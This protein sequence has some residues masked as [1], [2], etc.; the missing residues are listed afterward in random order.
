M[1]ICELT[2]IPRKDSSEG[3]DAFTKKFSY[4]IPHSKTNSVLFSQILHM[5][6]VSKLV[7]VIR[8]G[9]NILV[10]GTLF[11]KIPNFCR[12]AIPIAKTYWMIMS[13]QKR[14][15]NIPT[16]CTCQTFL[17]CA[18]WLKTNFEV[19]FKIHFRSEKISIIIMGP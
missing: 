9:K 12:I 18:N 6:T 3:S 1:C 11:P 13:P 8:F 14:I 10:K 16:I 7:I 15:K 19:I 4:T 17:Y 2:S 5:F